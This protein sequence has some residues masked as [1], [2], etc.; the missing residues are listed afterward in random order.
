VVRR[1]IRGGLGAAALSALL[2]AAAV[3]VLLELVRRGELSLG[4]AAA[5]LGGLLV[6]GTQL[7]SVGAGIGAVYESALFV[8][9]YLLFVTDDPEQDDRGLGGFTGTAPPSL[10]MR[11]VRAED[12]GFTYPSATRPALSGVHVRVG[13]GE[14]VALVGENGS[15]KSTLAKLLAGLYP[16]GRGHVTWNGVDYADVDITGVREQI[17]VLFQ[18]FVRYDLTLADNVAFGRRDRAADVAALDRAAAAAGADGIVAALPQGW[19]TR[20][21]PQYAGGTEL[22]GGQWQRLAIARAMYRDAPLVV[23]DEPTAALDPRA[24]AELF[25]T[26]RTLFAGRAVVLVS[27][28]FGSVRHADRIYVL[29]EGSV[30]E[31]G[32][33]DE[34]LALGGRYAEMF[35]LQRASLMG[36]RSEDA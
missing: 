1:R 16:A 13:A 30:V 15:G 10:P 11:E 26:V 9:D 27:H 20:I 5:A 12:V 17:A 28:R 36:D 34:L 19:A 4:S 21:G 7:Q 18:D 23:L 35:H 29:H 32:D 2:L 22:S 14:V 6:L 8:Q 24:E 3:T 31:C 33:H 25:R